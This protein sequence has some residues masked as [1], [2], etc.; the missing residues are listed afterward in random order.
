MWALAEGVQL[1]PK[2]LGRV[3]AL[4]R[5][6]TA[7]IS[8]KIE[9]AV[10]ALRELL[11]TASTP[12]AV[13]A[14]LANNFFT[15]NDPEFKSPLSSPARQIS[16]FLDLLVSTPEPAAPVPFT[17]DS[18][19]RAA[20]LLNEAFAGYFELYFPAEGKLSQQTE[21]WKRIHGVAMQAF[22]HY[23]N[24][25]VLATIEQ[26]RTRIQTYLVPFDRKLQEVLGITATDLLQIS[27][28]LLQ[29]LKRSAERLV[30]AAAAERKIR[31]T[32]IKKAEAD[33]LDLNGLKKL[34]AESPTY[35]PAAIE[36]KKSLDD[37]FVVRRKDVTESFVVT[38]EQYWD[39]QSVA[40]GSGP[41]VTYPTD[42]SV[43]EQRPVILLDES[44]GQCPTANEL[45]TAV[46]RLC[47]SALTNSAY[48]TEYLAHRDRTLEQETAGLFRRIV[49]SK[50]ELITNAYETPTGHLEHD[51]VVLSGKTVLIIEAKASPPDAPFRD[52][53]K[54]FVR[55]KRAY[56]S[57]SGIQ[58][59]Y[60]QAERLRARFEQD[61]PIPL[62]S[63]EGALLREIDP[64][65]YSDV[66]A[67]CIT[68]D[69]FGPLATDLTVLLE[70]QTGG[71]YPW[72]TNVFDLGSIGDAWQFLGWG[73]PELVRYLRDRDQCH[74][75][76]YGTDELEYAG[77]FILHDGLTSALDTNAD[78][79][80]LNPGYSDF[81]DELNRHLR[82]NGPPP[83]RNIKQPVLMNLRKSLEAGKPVFVSKAGKIRPDYVGVSR[84][85]PCPCGSGKRYKRCHGKETA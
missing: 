1:L 53:D 41:K 48:K 75:K 31:L 49:G 84:N 15:A 59:G 51:L 77:Y 72:V 39:L 62:Y 34:T 36:L 63:R 27:E 30:K 47:E 12:E 2:S 68:R 52:P 9:K 8:S 7:E 29:K 44:R 6:V 20:D 4:E 70:K 17:S 18:W 28:N 43:V 40:R 16:F 21:E 66:F 46:L 54:A 83:S 79:L 38:G 61:L 67:I 74:G 14:C 45:V 50:A 69:N 10:D 60:E 80:T 26:V 13:G 64:S 5:T 11:R 58:A 35:T 73:V 56:G 65:Q 76:V 19:G 22:L 23:W 3:A 85:A 25:G 37:L 55:L 82:S 78:L 32:L 42:P 71:P 33:N 81:F 24:T 57:D